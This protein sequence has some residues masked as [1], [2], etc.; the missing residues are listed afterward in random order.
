MTLVV[1]IRH[2]LTDQG[3][4]PLD[5]LR[6][7]RNALRIAG[8]IEYAADL[9][10]GEGRETLVACRRRPKR[11]QCLG[12]IWVVKLRDH[13][14]EAHCMACHETEAL[15]SG[16]EETLWAEGMMEPAPM[17]EDPGTGETGG[18]GTPPDR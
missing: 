15:I 8:F 3:E 16:W 4:L 7:R 5:N 17:L 1:D 18:N 9:K 2:W 12:L 6:V 11:R 13:R 10:P 14:I